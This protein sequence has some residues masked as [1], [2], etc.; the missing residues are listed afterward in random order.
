MSFKEAKGEVLVIEEMF[1]EAGPLFAAIEKRGRRAYR[2]TSDQHFVEI[3]WALHGSGAKEA[4]YEQLP[5][6]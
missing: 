2:A 4:A 3:V 5:S 1:N 6:H